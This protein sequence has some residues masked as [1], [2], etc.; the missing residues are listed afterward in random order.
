MI[1]LNEEERTLLSLSWES[2][3]PSAVQT[4]IGHVMLL[5][6]RLLNILKDRVVYLGGEDM[7]RI[8]RKDTELVERITDNAIAAILAGE[9]AKYG[10]EYV[11]RASWRAPEVPK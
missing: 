2:D 4:K 1:F 10:E 9:Y 11:P 7:R 3:E 5:S 8:P 6:R